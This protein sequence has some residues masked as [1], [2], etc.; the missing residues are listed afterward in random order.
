MAIP[1]SRS[2]PVDLKGSKLTVKLRREKSSASNGQA[3]DQPVRER[4]KSKSPR[5]SKIIPG[6]RITEL[7]LVSRS[8]SST[9]TK[10][11]PPTAVREPE[12]QQ[13]VN[14]E[15][16]PVDPVDEEPIDPPQ[17]AEPAVDVD[18]KQA[19][20]DVTLME[21]LTDSRVLELEANRVVETVAE[22][23]RQQL[24][25]S[26]YRFNVAKRTLICSEDS[27]SMTRSMSISS[28]RHETVKISPKHS[29][30]F[31]SCTYLSLKIFNSFPHYLLR[32]KLNSIY[33]KPC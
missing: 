9:P 28:C 31:L 7:K 24:Q 15:F 25:Q 27:N 1:K 10:A 19:D 5:N 14:P 16:H 17:E 32:T 6:V 4:S 33:N 20:E 2:E 30:L 23:Q 21:T 3:A 11:E 13:R 26:H 18:S 8:G 29:N 12:Q 22:H